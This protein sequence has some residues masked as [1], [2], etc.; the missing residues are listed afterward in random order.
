MSGLSHE[1]SR[2]ESV[3]NWNFVSKQPQKQHVTH[4]DTKLKDLYTICCFI[5]E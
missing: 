4:V 1:I 2:Q 3:R 5:E